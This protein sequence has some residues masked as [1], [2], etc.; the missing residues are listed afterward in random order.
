MHYIISS[1]FLISVSLS[2]W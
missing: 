2:S 1:I